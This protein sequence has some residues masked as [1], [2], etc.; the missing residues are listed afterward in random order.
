MKYGMPVEFFLLKCI[1]DMHDFLPQTP[2]PST[3]C[4][5]RLWVTGGSRVFGL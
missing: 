1:P 5:R 2:D 4:I 3:N